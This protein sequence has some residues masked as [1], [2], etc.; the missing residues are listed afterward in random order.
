MVVLS[1]SVALIAAACGSDKKS[2][3]GSATSAAA[4]PTTAA[5]PPTTAAASPTTAAATA[6]TASEATTAAPAAE[7]GPGITDSEIKI[8]SSFALSGPATAYAGI[9]KGAVAYFKYLNETAGGVKMADGKTRKINFVVEDDGFEAARALTNATKLNEEDKVFAIAGGLGTTPNVAML[10][11]VTSN[12]VPD[13]FIQDGTSA[14][15]Q[16]DKYP[17][18]IIWQPAY[19]L[20]SYLFAQYLKDN[21]PNAKVGILAVEGASATDYVDGFKKSIEGT[22]IEIVSEKVHSFADP[23]MDPYI[24]EFNRAGADTV[25]YATL[26]GYVSQ[27]LIKAKAIGF[28]PLNLVVNPGN[29]YEQG[30]KNAGDAANGIITLNFLKDPAAKEW[31]NDPDIAWY[32]DILSKYASDLNAND[33][34]NVQGFAWAQTLVAALEQSQPNR[35]SFMSAVRNLKDVKIRGLVDGITV[36]TSPTDPFP[37]E[38]MVFEKFENGAYTVEGS[39]VDASGKTPLISDAI[40]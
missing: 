21:K 36:N 31:A 18:A 10:P 40:K 35:E 39:P 22:G 17:T 32:K 14:F 38:S 6:T 19:S 24:D 20:E 16:I 26:P 28:Q 30:I 4:S 13:V 27:G 8:G 2:D 3:S 5:A 25:L 34:F 29:S 7:T 23:T 37:I 9:N 12:E 15:G 1:L 11:Y 33:Y